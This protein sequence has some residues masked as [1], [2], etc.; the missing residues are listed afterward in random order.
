MKQDQI[1]EDLCSVMNG[2]EI[3]R[4]GFAP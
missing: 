1:G 3:A 4:L 2:A